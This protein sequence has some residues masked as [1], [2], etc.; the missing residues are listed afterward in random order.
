MKHKKYDILAKLKQIKKSKLIGN[1]NTLNKEKD[2]LEDIKNYL[3]K[4][5]E[6]NKP[7]TEEF[8]G[9]QLKQLSDFNSEIIKK[10]EVSENRF[11]HLNHEIIYN[12]KQINKI[13]K[14]RETIFKKK[15]E[16]LKIKL[17]AQ[18]NKREN[19]K[20]KISSI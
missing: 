7:K 6:E 4:T 14:Q 12:L 8:S 16:L 11:N 19:F 13:E 1:L 5:L 15:K 2:K 20:S 3:S 17:E 18:E 9:T 10:L